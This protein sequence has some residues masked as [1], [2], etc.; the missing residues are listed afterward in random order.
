M[1]RIKREIEG[2]ER[3]KRTPT[4]GGKKQRESGG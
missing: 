2:G 4:P 1:Q 3:E